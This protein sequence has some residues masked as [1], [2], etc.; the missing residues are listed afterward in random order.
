MYNSYRISCCVQVR[1]WRTRSC[2]CRCWCC[3]TSRPAPTSGL[4]PS[5]SLSTS[6]RNRPRTRPATRSRP[7]NTPRTTAAAC[8]SPLPASSRVTVVFRRRR[9]H[10]GFAPAPIGCATV[11]T[12]CGCSW[13]SRR[14][15]P[16]RVACRRRRRR[17]TLARWSPCRRQPACWSCSGTRTWRAETRSP[18]SVCSSSSAG[19]HSV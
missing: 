18:L 19:W 3:A 9:R 5:P 16:C 2:R 11:R 14:P 1:C 4:P 13:G 10:R 12:P 8:W 17:S 7:T 15:T 6:S